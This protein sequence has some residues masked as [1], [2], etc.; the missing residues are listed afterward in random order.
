[1]WRNI[2][3]ANYKLYID[4]YFQHLY[5]GIIQKNTEKNDE[6]KNNRIENFR[7]TLII[8]ELCFLTYY[9]M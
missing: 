4:D 5:N 2:I 9:L 6:I 7:K 3:N 1:M 8:Q